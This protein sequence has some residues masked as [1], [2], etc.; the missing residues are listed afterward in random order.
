VA[1]SLLT[2]TAGAVPFLTPASG[3]IALH[4]RVRHPVTIVAAQHEH[5]LGIWRRSSEREDLAAFDR[6][7]RPL[8][9]IVV[10]QREALLPPTAVALRDDER[11]LL[12]GARFLI[13]VP[14]E[15]RDDPLS[16]WTGM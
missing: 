2:V 15:I 6:L 4:Q 13:D 14:N 9:S 10:C 5:G 3:G 7:L 1:R 12:E 11:S 16:A 8:R